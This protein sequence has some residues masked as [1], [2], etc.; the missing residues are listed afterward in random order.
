MNRLP[1][2]GSKFISMRKYRNKTDTSHSFPYMAI[3]W[4]LVN[5]G[6][7]RWGASALGVLLVAPGAGVWDSKFGLAESSH[8][9]LVDRPLGKDC[10]LDSWWGYAD[11][12]GYVKKVESVWRGVF[13]IP[14]FVCNLGIL[15]TCLA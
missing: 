14:C 13:E 3:I 9:D 1:Q 15:G 8:L 2:A 10:C 12:R 5:R 4:Q 6:S 11:A 7:E